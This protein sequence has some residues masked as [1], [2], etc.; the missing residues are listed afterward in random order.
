VTAPGYSLI[1]D[2][3][4]E[5]RMQVFSVVCEGRRKFVHTNVEVDRKKTLKS[6]NTQCN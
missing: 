6:S 4:N 5:R 1:D 3:T 2:K